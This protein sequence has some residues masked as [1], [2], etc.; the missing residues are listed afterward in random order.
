MG[1]AIGAADG[2]HDN[3]P[4]HSPRL[5]NL[6][7]APNAEAKQLAANAQEH[8]AV[9][10]DARM[11]PVPPTAEARASGDAESI[12]PGDEKSTASSSPEAP[13]P[14]PSTS[15]QLSPQM[16]GAAPARST[17]W[18]G[19]SPTVATVNLAVSIDARADSVSADAESTAP[20]GEKSTA[21]SIR[22]HP[23]HT[24]RH[25]PMLHP[26]LLYRAGVFGLQRI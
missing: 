22:S 4:G 5:A 16:D 13:A 15:A 11:D 6:M 12:A 19:A 17:S 9:P 25:G 20:S 14:Q 10:I 2:G 18:S 8:I 1:F 7:L 24:P 23:L 3:S 21:L 26:Q